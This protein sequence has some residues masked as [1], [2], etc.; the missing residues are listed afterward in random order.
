MLRNILVILGLAISLTSFTPKQESRDGVY[1]FTTPPLSIGQGVVVTNDGIVIGDGVTDSRQGIQELLSGDDLEHFLDQSSQ[2]FDAVELRIWTWFLGQ[3][4]FTIG[5]VNN[6]LARAH[7]HG[8]QVYLNT[9]EYPG[10][11]PDL[12]P[13]EY[14]A[15]KL[16][17]TGQRVPAL[18][19]DG[20]ISAQHIDKANPAA[21]EWMSGQLRSALT[22]FDVFDGYLIVEDRVSDW[23]HGSFPQ[24][25]RYWDSPTY[26]DAALDS[27]QHYLLLHGQDATQR[28]P[29]DRPELVSQFT[30]YVPSAPESALW[31][32]WYQWRFELFA[33]YVESLSNAVKSVQRVPVLYMPWQRVVDEFDYAYADDWSAN[34]WDVGYG[35]G[36][37]E[38]AIFGVSLHTLAKRGSIDAYVHEFGEDGTHELWPMSFNA[39]QLEKA[40]IALSDSYVTLGSFI[41]FFNYEGREIVSPELLQDALAIGRQ[42]E[43]K[44]FVAYD[45]ATL[46]DRSGRYDAHT[47][48]LWQQARTHAYAIDEEEIR[49]ASQLAPAQVFA[50]K[51]PEQ[52][53]EGVAAWTADDGYVYVRTEALP[54]NGP[55]YVVYDHW[56]A[57][58]LDAQHLMEYY[59]E[60]GLV[61]IHA[62]GLKG[63]AFQIITP[64]PQGSVAWSEIREQLCELGYQGIVCS[65][66]S[67]LYQ[68]VG[69]HSM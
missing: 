52:I 39:L 27:F 63:A 16:A 30:Q 64:G 48:A 10:T 40:K 25:V 61:A 19:N 54:G 24:Y 15:Y 12:L 23:V 60:H 14:Q 11:H 9:W 67:W 62:D 1:A 35:P 51:L 6:F 38:N 18:V 44:I 45:V 47:S 69:L 8:L 59:P 41:Q 5:T 37:P 28:F 55:Y 58:L 17:D 56:N 32:Y 42:N 26:S 2:Q 29:V 68:P 34:R 57:P 31:K 50:R 53:P 49:N 65:P 33:D 20:Q 43:A 13:A 46:Y 3:N 21:L 7:A 66:N 36:N 22:S 4:D